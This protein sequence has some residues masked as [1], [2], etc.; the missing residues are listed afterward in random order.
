M[1]VFV[2][3]LLDLSSVDYPKRPAAVI[4]TPLCNYRCPSCQNW[5][6]LEMKPEYEKEIEDVFRFIDRANP[7]IEAV[8]VTGGEPTLYPEFLK[9]V[10]K[11]SHSRGLLFGFDTNG[12]LH[13]VIK[14]LI[15]WSDLVSL[16]LKASPTNPD[17]MEKMIGLPG[18]GKDIAANTL[19]SLEELMKHDEIYLD[20]RTTVIPTLNDRAHEFTSIGEILRSL[21]YEAR[22]SK[23]TA[24]YTLQEFVPEHACDENI[25]RIKSPSPRVL[26]NLAD[27]TRLTDVYVKHRDEGF[28]IHK[29]ELLYSMKR[30]TEKQTV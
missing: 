1:K 5:N 30:R 17:S 3:G 23:N 13:Q 19:Q 29:N 25:R 10:S 2:A 12:F 16:D 15:T 11:Y 6:I 26:M 7:T 9:E 4:F 20:L 21:N 24:S 28:M 8:K 27:A 22:A 18:K 14:E